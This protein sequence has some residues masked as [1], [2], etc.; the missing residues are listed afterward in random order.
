MNGPVQ[1]AL[2]IPEIMD[3]CCLR[4]C[5]ILTRVGEILW[6]AGLD[7]DQGKGTNEHG[8]QGAARSCTDRAVK[9]RVK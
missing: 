4:N 2:L 5:Y 3:G 9:T 1:G 8:D 7:V 6:S